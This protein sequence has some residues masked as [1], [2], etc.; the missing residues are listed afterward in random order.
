MTNEFSAMETVALG[1]TV[2]SCLKTVELR[3]GNMTSNSHNFIAILQHSIF[4]LHADHVFFIRFRGTCSW[5]FQIL[6]ICI[7]FILSRKIRK[8]CAFKGSQEVLFR[9]EESQ[10]KF[11]DF[12]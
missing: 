5:F 1:L 9:L 11:Q 6:I 12:L 10:R 2:F 3:D 4:N 8:N 7:G